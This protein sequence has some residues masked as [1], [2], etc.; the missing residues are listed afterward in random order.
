VKGGARARIREFLERSVGRIVSTDEIAEVA[1]I[2]DYRRRIRELRNEEGMDIR[3]YRDDVSLA[4]NQYILASLERRPVVARAIPASLRTEILERNGFTCQQCGA[5]GGDPDPTDPP[6]KL[7]LVIDHVVPV[8][9]G[10]RNE[11][12]NLR[13]LC[14]ACN[15]G[16]SNIM[17]PSESAMNLLARVR[18]A[19]RNLQREVFEAL[20][21]TFEGA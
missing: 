16:R 19:P 11:R 17:S 10:G 21:R 15:Q 9:Q 4:P 12:K 3:S 18:K 20:R 7:R 5:T 1:G 14:S 13:V 6:R 8:S 2:R